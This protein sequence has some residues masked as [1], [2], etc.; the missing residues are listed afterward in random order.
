M[1]VPSYQAALATLALSSQLPLKRNLEKI[2]SQE[3][4]QDLQS[5]YFTEE[6]LEKFVEDYLTLKISA[7][8][9][10]LEFRDKAERL[11]RSFLFFDTEQKNQLIPPLIELPL[12]GLKAIINQIR[13]G[14]RKQSE[15]LD[16]FIE[17]DPKVAIK[18]EVIA[19]G[20]F[21]RAKATQPSD[22]K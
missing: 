5:L 15:Y 9:L 20:Q 16:T 6:T 3:N 1:L 7:E 13:V 19:S 18:F 14:H 8:Q 11:I 10:R 22:Q 12:E 17:K 4:S 2:L 21:E